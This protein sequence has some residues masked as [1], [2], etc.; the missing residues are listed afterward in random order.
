MTYGLVATPMPAVA[1][2]AMGAMRQDAGT[3]VTQRGVSIDGE[4]QGNSVRQPQDAPGTA[5]PSKGD[6]AS[7]VSAILRLLSLI[8]LI[9]LGGCAG[10]TQPMTDIELRAEADSCAKSSLC[11][12]LIE[13][14]PSVLALAVNDARLCET[15]ARIAESILQREGVETRR[16]VVRL[17]APRRGDFKT[18]A[19][20]TQLLHTFIA[21]NVG[22]RWYAVDNGSLPFCDRICKLTEAL[23]GVE[24]IS[25]DSKPRVS[26]GEAVIAG[27]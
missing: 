23:H 2:S 25:G 10:L 13:D 20:Q 27:R 12:M 9:A 7:P 16:Y 3:P 24:L 14:R 18:E 19:A 1:Q 15:N 17:K 26:V 8:G 6:K 5:T 4:R 11:R 22:E 21:A